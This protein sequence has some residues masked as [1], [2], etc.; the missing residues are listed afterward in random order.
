M[1]ASHIYNF[2][3]CIKSIVVISLIVYTRF[4]MRLGFSIDKSLS[5]LDDLMY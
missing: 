4:T 5:H 1:L 2:C 3:E